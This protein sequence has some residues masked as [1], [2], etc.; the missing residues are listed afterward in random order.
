MISL[1]EVGEY[2]NRW[3][4]HL[5]NLRA[6]ESDGLVREDIMD[7]N[8]RLHAVFEAIRAERQ[9]QDNKWGSLDDIGA[10]SVSDYLLILRAELKEAEEAWVKSQGDRQALLEIL[11]VAAVA[12]AALLTVGHNDKSGAGQFLGRF[13]EDNATFLWGGEGFHDEGVIL[14]VWKPYSHFA[15]NAAFAGVGVSCRCGH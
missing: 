2:Y 9:Y 13:Q 4:V 15:G 12:V 1:E 3:L 5:E 8:E 7:W 14:I 6:H 10:R 11:Q